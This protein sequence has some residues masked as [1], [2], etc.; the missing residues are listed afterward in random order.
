MNIR[1]IIS[2]AIDRAVL[3]QYAQKMGR[4]LGNYGLDMTPLG[5][6]RVSTK[7]LSDFNNFCFQV[8]YAIEDKNYKQSTGTRTRTTRTNTNINNNAYNNQ[9]LKRPGDNAVTDLVNT[10]YN[11]ADDMYHDAGGR[12]AFPLFNGMGRSFIRGYN[13]G[14]N[15]FNKDVNKQNQPQQPQQQTRRTTR[16]TA[17]KSG[18]P[19]YTLMGQTYI[20][21]MNEYN[22]ARQ[23][24][25]RGING[26]RGIKELLDILNDIKNALRRT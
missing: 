26:V 23:A 25:P 8:K 19:L 11:W 24:N 16:R 21:I 4:Y 5:N 18:I 17:K 12:E 14:V 10:T 2:E 1:Q 22:Y 20:N 6:E 15:A 3:E 9:Y 7:F 13:S